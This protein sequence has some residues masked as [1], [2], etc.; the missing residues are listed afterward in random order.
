MHK[1]ISKLKKHHML[2]CLFFKKN[3]IKVSKN[4]TFKISGKIKKNRI[5]IEG[6]ENTLEIKKGAKIVNC[7]IR[8]K[9]KKNKLVI[10]EN[11]KIRNSDILLDTENGK[12]IINKEVISGI[13][14]DAQEP[15]LIEIGEDSMISYNVEIRN[16]DA[17]RIIDS[18]T[19]KSI[20]R[21]KPVK[22]GKHVWIGEGARILKGITV[23]DGAII[24]TG[25]IVTK[26][27]KKNTIVAGNPGKVI[28]ENCSWER[29]KNK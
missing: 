1:I 14:I 24:G 7:K 4:N 27:V 3:I 22:I 8:I 10:C 18:S 29:E 6:F 20:N 26:D 13:K 19:K 17:H 28:K 21:G 11:C 16:T 25:S 23:E 15:Y 12:V 9:G 2:V 5:E